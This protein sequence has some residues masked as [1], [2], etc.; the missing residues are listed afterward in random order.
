MKIVE[1]FNLWRYYEEKAEKNRLEMI[2]SIKQKDIISSEIQEQVIWLNSI[3]NDIIIKTK[4][5]NKIS[6]SLEWLKANLIDEKHRYTEVV[7]KL[8]SNIDTYNQNL[9]KLQLETE[10]IKKEI[11]I[12]KINLKEIKKNQK[13]IKDLKNE[14]SKLENHKTIFEIEFN[15]KEKALIL[16]TEK[17]TEEWK[18]FKDYVKEQNERERKLLIKEQRLKKLEQSLFSKKK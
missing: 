13:L 11:D 12:N 5:K 4:E 10:D 7:T 17:L 3:K 9:D 18:E 1:W 6:C 16:E 2:Q 14:I 15:E 8:K